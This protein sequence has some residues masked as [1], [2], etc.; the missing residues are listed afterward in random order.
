[1]DDYF[2]IVLDENKKNIRINLKLKKFSRINSVS[3]Y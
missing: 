1:M 2:Q 3:L